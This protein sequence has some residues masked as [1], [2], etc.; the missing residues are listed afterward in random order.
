MTTFGLSVILAALS[1][2]VVGCGESRKTSST[3]SSAAAAATTSAGG[4]ATTAAAAAGTTAGAPPTAV[5]ATT[6]AAAMTDVSPATT[7]APG[8]AGGSTSADLVANKN[9]TVAVITQGDA[10][11][12]WSVVQKGAEQAGADL[13]ITV[14]YQGAASNAGVQAR[15]IDKAIT[16]KVSG[17]AVS[18]ASKNEVSIAAANVT[19]AGIPLVTLNSGA[20]QYQSLG[21]VTHIGQSEDEA[22]RGA[23]Q[24]LKAAGATFMLCVMQE[25]SNVGI[26]NRCRSASQTFLPGN[27]ATVTGG[28]S[29]EETQRKIKAALQASTTIDSVLAT[30]SSSALLAQNAAG[31]LSRKVTI[32]AID[33]SEPLLTAIESGGITFTIDQ[34]Q[35]NQGYFAVVVLYLAITKKNALAAGLPVAAGPSIIDTSNVVAVKDLFLRTSR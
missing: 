27:F 8:A 23:G 10:G 35:Y 28:A 32:G 34:Q 26:E 18:V 11:P 2:I 1:L 20:E 22:G 3:P 7:A 21:A 12:F 5:P 19:K 6:A 25:N 4:A 14:R 31:E 17:I 30:D 29:P 9:I 13:G 16:D 15:M 24:R 33:V